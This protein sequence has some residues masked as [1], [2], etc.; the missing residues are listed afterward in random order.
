M[1]TNTDMP[2]LL[3]KPKCTLINSADTEWRLD[4][5]LIEIIDGNR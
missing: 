4:V 1:E 3:N 5:L 2:H